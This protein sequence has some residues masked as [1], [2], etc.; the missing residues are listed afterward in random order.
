M[1]C[2]VFRKLA[3]GTL[4]GQNATLAKQVIGVA[5]AIKDG[6]ENELAKRDVR[7]NNLTKIQNSK[8]LSLPSSIIKI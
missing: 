4:T 5:S 1:K 3:D 7:V 6:F 2:F 8:S